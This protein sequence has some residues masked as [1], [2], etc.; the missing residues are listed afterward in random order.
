MKCQV[1]ME[2]GD[3]NPLTT[4]LWYIFK[5][6]HPSPAAGHPKVV[7]AYGPELFLCFE[8]RWLPHLTSTR[9]YSR[10]SPKTAPV[11]LLPSESSPWPRLSCEKGLA[12][13]ARRWVGTSH[14]L[15][16]STPAAPQAGKSH[17]S[18]QAC[19]RFI[20][21]GTAQELGPNC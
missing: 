13:P 3:D 12:L 5:R 14:S 4:K 8:S 20:I 7:P 2:Q 18:A 6:D 11:T 19:I 17:A 1:P 9:R 10:L 21:T 16:G 15:A